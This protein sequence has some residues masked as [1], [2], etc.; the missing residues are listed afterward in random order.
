MFVRIVP[1]PSVNPCIPSPC[2][3]YSQCRESGSHAICSCIENYIGAPPACRPECAISSEC[4]LDK[5]CI[6]QRCVDPCPGACG[7]NARCQAINHNPICS[8]SSGYA[9]DPFIQCYP[10]ISKSFHLL[11]CYNPKALKISKLHFWKSK[12]KSVHKLC[13]A[14]QCFWVDNVHYSIAKESLHAKFRSFFSFLPS[15]SSLIFH[16]SLP[17][18][19]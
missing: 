5:A 1:E 9:G 17:Y 7:Q 19:S 10:E 12:R 16:P 2:G 3:P 15:S 8:C 14:H 13:S 4:S 11:S 6:S 18:A